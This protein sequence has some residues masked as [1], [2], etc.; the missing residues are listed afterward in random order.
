MLTDV[1]AAKSGAAKIIPAISKRIESASPIPFREVINSPTVKG[2]MVTRTNPSNLSWYA[3]VVKPAQKLT[4]SKVIPPID[5][6]MP[7]RSE[8]KS[9]AI[10]AMDMI[11]YEMKRNVFFLSGISARYVKKSVNGT[12]AAAS[13]FEKMDATKEMGERYHF[14]EVTYKER[15]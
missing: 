13:G 15:R 8:E 6:P 1:R 10:P 9:T 14:L 3:K 7:N 2:R 4:G 5:V 12:K 11:P